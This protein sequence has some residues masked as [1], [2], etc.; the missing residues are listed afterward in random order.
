MPAFKK[1]LII[2]L[3]GGIGSGKSRVCEL[4]SDLG[5]DIVNAD[6]IAH[7]ITQINTPCYQSIIEHFG[8][9]ILKKDK[10]LDRE[11]LKT[12]IFQNTTEKKWL[13]DLLHPLIWQELNKAANNSASPYV[14]LEIPLLIEVG[15]H[16]MIDRVL[17]VDAQQAIQIK[18]II[19]RDKVS[20][21]EA[22]QI[23]KHQASREQRLALADDVIENDGDNQHLSQQVAELH[24]KYS[25][26]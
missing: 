13:E 3:T 17:V 24:K 7:Q 21:E 22:K 2:G 19:Q 12:V 6:E 16:P 11:K 23:I 5:I 4:F 25:G 10:T 18:R 1:P 14:I 15:S 26:Q 20:K 9:V 8:K